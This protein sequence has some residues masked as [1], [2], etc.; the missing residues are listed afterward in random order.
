MFYETM[1]ELLPNIKVVID[2]GSGSIQKYYPIESFAT[3]NS[4]TED[5]SEQ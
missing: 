5:N 1:G 4:V 2:D 3:I